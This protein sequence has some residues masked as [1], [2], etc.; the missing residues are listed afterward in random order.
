MAQRRSYLIPCAFI[1]AFLRKHLLLNSIFMQIFVAQE[2]I[3]LKKLWVSNNP[4]WN[5]SYR[6][7]GKRMK[8]NI[9]ES[10]PKREEVLT[11]YFMNCSFPLWLFLYALGM[12]TDKQIVELVDINM[13]KGNAVNVLI[14]TIC[15]ADDHFEG[16]RTEGYSLKKINELFKKSKFPPKESAKDCLEIYLFPCLSSFRQ[17]ALF[18]IYMVKCLL[19]AYSG[20]RMCENKN[21]F[22]NKRLD[23]ASELLERELQTHVKHAERWMVKAMQRDTR[24]I[25]GLRPIENYLDASIIT[26]GINRAFSCGRW[27][28]HFNRSEKVAGVVATLRRTN[29]LQITSDMRKTRLQYARKSGG[30]ARFPYVP[31]IK[32]CKPI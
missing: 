8:V 26:N 12:P 15:Y 23:L 24:G 4:N 20:Q 16:F 21:D 22:R 6:A 5:I 14:N 17:K 32:L 7:D 29:P 3:C 25:T 2:Q 31:P 27:S 10:S 13:R 9:E 1:H 30:D 18:L 19:Q 11:V 28:H